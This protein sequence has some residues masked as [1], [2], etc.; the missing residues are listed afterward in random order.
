M[1]VLRSPKQPQAARSK[2]WYPYYAGYTQSFAEDVFDTYLSEAT[3]IVDP[4]NGSGTTTAVASAKGLRS[5]GFDINPAL[6][7]VAR[8]RVTPTSIAESLAPIALEIVDLAKRVT[9]RERVFEPLGSWLRKPAVTELRRLQ[10][11]IHALT[12]ADGS[13]EDELAVASSTAASA[14][15]VLSAFF[16]T[17]LFAACRDLLKSFRSSNP[18]WVRTPETHRHRLQP[19]G[20]NIASLFLGR[21]GYLSSRL[22]GLT[23]PID[24]HVLTGPAR[25]CLPSAPKYDACLS[26]PPYATRIDYVKSSLPE[27]AILGLPPSE[28]EW[29][30]TASTG[31]P[32]VRN[33][34]TTCSDLG[35]EAT[36]LIREVATHPSHGSASYY[37]PWLR[38]YLG[39]LD[40]T[41]GAIDAAVKPGGAIAL[42]VQDSYYKALK[43][44]LQALVSE[45][46]EARGRRLTH[47]HDFE[48]RHSMARMNSRARE[49]LRERQNVESLVVFN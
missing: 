27:L 2:D 9:P 24:C 20:A 42:V 29:L 37:G 48:V 16:Y 44:D 31:T 14:M 21:V 22:L 8:A 25:Q 19:S 39:A 6:T 23:E 3:S 1:V 26:S 35:P 49:H 38:N 18:T 45:S 30:R 4:W 32:V 46:L 13:L 33:A 15:P 11:A 47:R 12:S 17:A 34:A 5:D 7:I 40:E 28:I 43:I 41:L 10:H 36:R